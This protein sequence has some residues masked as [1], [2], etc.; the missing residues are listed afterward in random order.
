[1]GGSEEEPEIISEAGGLVEGLIPVLRE[2][3]AEIIDPVQLPDWEVATGTHTEVMFWEFREG[4]NRYLSSLANTD[5]RSLADVIEFNTAHPDAE[6][7]WHSQ[8]L[9]EEANKMG[10]LGDPGYAEALAT[11]QRLGETAFDVPMS[12]HRLDAIFHP[13]FDVRG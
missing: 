5:I 7:R 6:L 13:P 12:E 2:L 3:G 10:P 1:M 11:S 4:I 9:L 8:N